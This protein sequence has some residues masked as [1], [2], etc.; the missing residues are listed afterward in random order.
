[1]MKTTTKLVSASDVTFT[2]SRT[3]HPFESPTLSM[4]EPTAASIHAAAAYIRQGDLVAFPTETVYGLG[5]NALDSQAVE[6]VYAAKHRPADNPLILHIASIQYLRK[7]IL[8]QHIPD[9]YDSLIAKFW[10]G[11]LT[12]IL[13]LD[14]ESTQISKLCTS[15]QST[16]A[17]RMP[18]NQLALA[19][20]ATAGVPLAAPSANTSTKPSP[21]SAQHVE[22]DLH[23]RLGLILDGG[24]SD[25]GLESTVVDG[26]VDPPQI[27]RPGG[28]SLEE[29]RDVKGWEETIVHRA[30]LSSAVAVPRTP[31]MKYRHYSPIAQVILFV[32]GAEPS[33]SWLHAN[34]INGKAV[35]LCRTRN[36]APE[37]A[38]SLGVTDYPLGQAGKDISRNLFE[39]LRC[40]DARGAEVILVEGVEETNE[41]LAI[42]NRLRKAASLTI[43]Q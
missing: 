43:D 38:G 18:A 16:F 12:I 1:M 10:P 2:P 41:G 42:M 36:W 14:N 19:L 25:V 11:P 17:V 20:I 37:L 4:Q 40:L 5:A 8:P 23:G 21:T 35:F 7:L 24:R 15:G 3:A 33:S 39:T 28:I 29:I 32:C 9:I 22:H 26:L 27:L 34:G 6:K 30:D 31:G 13:P